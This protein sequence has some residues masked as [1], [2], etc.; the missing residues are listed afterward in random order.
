MSDKSKE[1]GKASAP[2]EAPP[3]ETE[4]ERLDR[5]RRSDANGETRGE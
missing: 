2:K 4:N 5:L 1:S 3:V